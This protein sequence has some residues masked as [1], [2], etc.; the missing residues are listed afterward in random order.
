MADRLPT[1]HR[2]T[3]AVYCDFRKSGTAREGVPIASQ[4]LEL[5]RQLA[6]LERLLTGGANTREMPR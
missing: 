4:I 6:L 2:S 3:D 5:A 1:K